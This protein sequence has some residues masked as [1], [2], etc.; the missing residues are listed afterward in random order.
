MQELGERVAGEVPGLLR[1]ALLLTRDR[2]AAEDLV[3]DTVVRAL[4]RA[5]Q[6][7]GEASVATWLHRIMFTRFVDGTRRTAPELRA[8]EELVDAVEAAWRDDAYTVAAEVVIERA[9]QREELRDALLRLPVAYRTAVVLHDV[10]GLTARAVAEVQGVSLAA[11]KQRIRRGREMLVSALARGAERR[12]ALTGVPLNCWQARSRID[13]YLAGELGTRE[14]T[15]LEAHLAGCP[16]C[17]ALYA[18]IVGV[19][20]ALGGLRDPDSVVPPR[21]AGRVREA[22]GASGPHRPGVGGTA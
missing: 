14:R 22:L 6:F 17:P 3:Q 11:S 7:R 16:T 20:A 21:L 12:A 4:E 10:E 9:E 13:D 1:Y 19:T 15:R 18:G 2:E 5:D 8:E